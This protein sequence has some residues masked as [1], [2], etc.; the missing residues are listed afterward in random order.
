[1]NAGDYSV[2]LYD[3]SAA[4]H[5]PNR[6]FGG[7]GITAEGQAPIDGLL[8]ACSARVWRSAR[9]RDTSDLYH[10]FPSPG[11]SR[12]VEAAYNH[13][14]NRSGSYAGDAQMTLEVIDADGDPLRVV[15][16]A[17]NRSAGCTA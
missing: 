16:A 6:N 11:I 3:Q 15:S 5:K 8:G 17:S 2:S 9:N 14:L 13:L 7:W 4:A 12:T 10:I 1:M